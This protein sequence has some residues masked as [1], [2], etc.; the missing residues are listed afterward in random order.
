MTKRQIIG[1]A[2]FIIFLVAVAFSGMFTKDYPCPKTT[3]HCSEAGS[4]GSYILGVIR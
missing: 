1:L 2:L 3:I 4:E